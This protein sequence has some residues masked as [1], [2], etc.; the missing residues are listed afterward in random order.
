[1]LDLQLTLL[2]GT[3]HGEEWPPSPARA[4]QAVLAGARYRF[5]HGSGWEPGFDRA[6]RWLEERPPPVIVA[7]LPTRGAG[8]VIYGPD[9]DMDLWVRERINVARGHHSK[10]T[11]DRSSLRSEVVRSPQYVQ[12]SVHY[13]HAEDGDPP[14]ELAQLAQSVVA[15]GRGI[16]LEPIR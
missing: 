10:K 12:G 13:L 14:Q 4:Y 15:L 6:L 1:M 3:F 16:D 9:N 2:S 11:V 5:R 7:P 8:Y